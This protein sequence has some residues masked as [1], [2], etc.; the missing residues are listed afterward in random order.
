MTEAPSIF[1]PNFSKEFVGRMLRSM[2][3]GAM[4]VIKPFWQALVSFLSQHWLA[5][6]I[7]LFITFIVLTFKAKLG[8]WGSLGSFL[9]NLFYFGILFIIGLIKGPEIF[10]NDLFNALT[11]LILYP[12]CYVLVRIVL[13]KMGVMRRF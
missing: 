9:Y 5:V 10:I 1:D 13:R 12:V 8:Y 6:I 3:D 11:A 2:D 7:F 4:L